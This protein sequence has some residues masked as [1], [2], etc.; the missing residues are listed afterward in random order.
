LSVTVT[1]LV[2]AG[3]STYPEVQSGF[4]RQP[5]PIGI[6]ERKT[7]LERAQAASEILAAWRLPA[8]V[9]DTSGKILAANH[10]V[11]KYNYLFERCGGDRF[12]LKD[13][14]A[15]TRLRAAI[16]NNCV[17]GFKSALSFPARKNASTD[18]TIVVHVLPL[19]HSEADS[20]SVCSV[21]AVFTP[22]IAPEPPS[23]ELL[24]SLFDLTTAEAR[25]ARGLANRKKVDEIASDGD[26][27]RNTI[28]KHVRSV[29]EKTGC[30]RQ[31]DL[32][33]LLM[34]ASLQSVL[35]PF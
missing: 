10:F 20:V 19:P 8:L 7:M 35:R 34:G 24:Q 30:K 21:L 15:R 11:E 27:S 32:V 28:R 29:L 14:G 25:V 13:C 1:Q 4:S 22:V 9:L 6:L 12:V 18:P 33:M 26:V 16:A 5:K 2:Q 23:V 31:L 3:L 17:S